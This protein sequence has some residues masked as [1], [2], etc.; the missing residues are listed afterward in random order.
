M[1]ICTSL[2]TPGGQNTTPPVEAK[3]A[4]TRKS[5]VVSHPQNG[6][7]GVHC[8]MSW[9]SARVRKIATV[10][11]PPNPSSCDPRRRIRSRE[12]RRFRSSLFASRPRALSPPSSSPPSP[13]ALLFAALRSW[14]ALSI[15]VPDSTRKLRLWDPGEGLVEHS[16]TFFLQECPKIDLACRTVLHGG[17]KK[18]K[19][20]GK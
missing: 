16:G 2:D 19:S 7:F 17:E 18:F 11:V 5:A 1:A 12:L 3:H 10:I 15:G 13:T 8:E 6:P 9:P 14:R 4:H 20:S